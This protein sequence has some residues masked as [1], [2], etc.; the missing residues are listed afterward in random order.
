MRTG[1]RRRGGEGRMAALY[2]LLGFAAQT[3]PD[4]KCGG[5]GGG[6]SERVE[7]RRT[8]RRYGKDLDI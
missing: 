5:G 6:A 1:S 4:G 2:L 7:E 3:R 8:G